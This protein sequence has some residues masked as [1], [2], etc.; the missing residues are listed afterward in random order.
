[1]SAWQHNRLTGLLLSTG[2]NTV[3]G[4]QASAVNVI[5]AD[6]ALPVLKLVLLVKGGGHDQGE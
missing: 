2:A 4:P 6:Q 3:G 5:S 1:M